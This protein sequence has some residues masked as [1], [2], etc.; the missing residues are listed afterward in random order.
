MKGSRFHPQYSKKI[1]IKMRTVK[2]GERNPGYTLGRGTVWLASFSYWTHQT[3]A[4]HGVGVC[5]LLQEGQLGEFEFLREPEG[6]AKSRLAKRPWSPQTGVLW[7]GGGGWI[8]L[9]TWWRSS[10]VAA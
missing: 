1:K 5:C 2:P 9:R 6:K 10:D 7:V 3:G 4:R 8:S